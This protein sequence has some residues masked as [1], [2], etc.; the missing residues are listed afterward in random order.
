M[1]ALIGGIQE[2]EGHGLNGI[3]LEPSVS[4]SQVM[5][6]MLTGAFDYYVITK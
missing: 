3:L 4:S 5:H 1:E 2:K 6:T